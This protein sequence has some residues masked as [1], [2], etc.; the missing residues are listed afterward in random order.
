MSLK[1]KTACVLIL[2]FWGCGGGGIPRVDWNSYFAGV[3]LNDYLARTYNACTQTGTIEMVSGQ[4]ISDNREMHYIIPITVR[5]SPNL[6]ITLTGINCDLRLN[7]I[8]CYGS[9]SGPD[10]LGTLQGPP[11]KSVTLT[12]TRYPENRFVLY[13]FGTDSITHDLTSC[14]YT[15]HAY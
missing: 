11:P 8:Q 13:V 6:D 9:P 10:S 7:A 3:L 1:G 4:T 2:A 15:V 12:M 14:G 5:G